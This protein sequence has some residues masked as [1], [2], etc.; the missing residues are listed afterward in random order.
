MLKATLDM[1]SEPKHQVVIRMFKSYNS[2][3]ACI[4]R[5]GRDVGL[6]ETALQMGKLFQIHS[7]FTIEFVVIVVMRSLSSSLHQ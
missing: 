5:D 3:Q 7:V 4:N 2:K 6:L 1:T